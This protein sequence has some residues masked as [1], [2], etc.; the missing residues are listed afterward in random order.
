MANVDQDEETGRNDLRCLCC[1]C[2]KSLH[3][4]TACSG[5]RCMCPGLVLD[6]DEEL[7]AMEPID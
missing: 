5:G 3:S 2:P 6:P 1:G 4:W 7:E